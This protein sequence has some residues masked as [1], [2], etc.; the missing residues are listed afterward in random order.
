MISG[1]ERRFA[2]RG[3][4]VMSSDAMVGGGL[5]MRVGEEDIGIWV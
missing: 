3:D 1:L 4:A 2:G 5:K